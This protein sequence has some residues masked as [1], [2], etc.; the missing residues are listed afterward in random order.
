MRRSARSGESVVMAKREEPWLG[1]KRMSIVFFAGLIA[2]RG[3]R[4]AVVLSGN[5]PGQSPLDVGLSLALRRRFL[6]F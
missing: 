5:S 4:F 3:R 1:I 2:F 6:C